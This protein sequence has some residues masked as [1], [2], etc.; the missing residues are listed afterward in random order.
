MSLFALKTL[1]SD[2]GKLLTALIGVTFSLV[3]VNV[4][5]GL[6]VGLIGRASVLIDNGGA[7]IWVSHR[8]TE[9]VDLPH[10]IPEIWLNR[11]R[12]L[13]GVE[14]AVP[15]IVGKGI[16]T[17]PNG[18]FEDV[19]IIGS[20]PT[21]QLGSGW[22]FTEGDQSVLRQPDAISVDQLDA[23]K[24]AYPE[25]GDVLEVN[26]RRAKVAAKTHGILGFMTIPYLFTT[27]DTA[28][29]LSRM[30][31]GDCSFFQIRATPETDIDNLCKAI[32]TQLPDA[33]VFTAG[34]FARLSQNYWLQRTGIGVSFGGATALGLL[35][36]LVMVAQSLYALA[37]DHMTEYATL[38]AIG[39]ENHHIYQVVIL[40]ATAVAALGTATGVS[41][42]FLLQHFWNLPL[43]PL[44][45][46]PE[47]LLGSI[48][49]VFFICLSAAALPIQ[50]IRGADPALVLQG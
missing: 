4:Q 40:Q 1:F 16:A 18:G 14:E 19:W 23:R 49:L 10:S 12:G 29:R 20:E 2:R 35:V 33:D 25:V 31:E 8:L 28:R 30:P 3:L 50:R 24:L 42:V 26:G 11:I 13:P 6:F 9:N 15:Y 48:G 22:S 46:P 21:T 41:L 7:D 36:G 43:A 27:V 45:I 34:E 17:L 38:K 37:L 32:R 47:L 39:A 44:V 5:G